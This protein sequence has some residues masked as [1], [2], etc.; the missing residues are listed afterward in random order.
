MYF[1]AMFR[2]ALKLMK[3][4][5]QAK[6]DFMQ[7]RAS[8]SAL[9]Y[10]IMKT[11]V[12]FPEKLISLLVP[13]IMYKSEPR[14][15]QGY[16]SLKTRCPVTRSVSQKSLNRSGFFCLDLKLDCSIEN[17]SPKPYSVTLS[18]VSPT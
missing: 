9:R 17:G 2:N 4:E 14:L 8:A 11:V 1:Y 13:P 18:K 6:L 5:I 15:L 12:C 10:E 3:I 7:N 16:H